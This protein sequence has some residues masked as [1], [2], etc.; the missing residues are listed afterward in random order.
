VNDLTWVV[1]RYVGRPARRR[2]LSACLVASATGYLQ[3]PAMTEILLLC[4]ANV[5]RSPM[6]G[7]LLARELTAGKVTGGKVTRGTVTEGEVTTAGGSVLVRSAATAG[8][9][10]IPPPAEV[11]GVMAAHG[12]DVSGHRSHAATAGDLAGADLILAMT[13]E[14]L[15]HAVVVA[16]ATWPRAFT[17]RELVRRGDLAGRR[18]P[19]ETLPGWLTRL[20]DGRSRT[21]LLGDSAQ[22]DI[23]DPIGGP[24]SGY[25]QAAAELWQLTGRLVDLC[26]AALDS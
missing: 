9:D 23:P 6:A 1:G 4:T 22:D 5:C 3:A 20:H 7:A 10:G 12:L 2:N 21:A 25:E 8:C 11:V 19:G 26:W 24:L 14:Q 15:R 16:P 17:L 18:E 13:R